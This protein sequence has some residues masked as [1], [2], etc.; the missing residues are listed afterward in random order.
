[1]VVGGVSTGNGGCYKRAIRDR[2][3][4]RINDSRGAR[5]CTH[6]IVQLG[7]VKRRVGVVSVGVRNNR[8]VVAYEKIEK[9]PI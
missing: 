8:R 7:S 1:M 4:G 3:A 2:A 5:S 9:D 6:E